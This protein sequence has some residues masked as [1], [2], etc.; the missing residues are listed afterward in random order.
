MN[1][2]NKDLKTNKQCAKQNIKRSYLRSLNCGNEYVH[3]AAVRCTHGKMCSDCGRF[4]EKGTLEYFMTSGVFH[5]WIVIHN[6]AVKFMR[7]ESPTDLTCELK[8]LMERLNDQKTLLKMTEAEAQKFMDETYEILSRHK[9]SD[10]ESIMA[11]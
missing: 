1:K 7:G 11:F 6:R 2:E 9:I 4:I 5:I 8:N 10:N 3:N